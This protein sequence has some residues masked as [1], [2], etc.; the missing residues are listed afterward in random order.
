MFTFVDTGNGLNFIPTFI[1]AMFKGM[2]YEIKKKS[3]GTVKSTS[4]H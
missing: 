2:C 4:F 3:N 1:V